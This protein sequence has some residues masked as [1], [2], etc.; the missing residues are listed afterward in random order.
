[1]MRLGQGGGN[2]VLLSGPQ[3][4]LWPAIPEGLGIRASETAFG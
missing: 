1:M 2:G 3:A 4:T